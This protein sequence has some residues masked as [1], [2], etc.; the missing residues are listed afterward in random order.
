[1]AHDIDMSNGQANMAYVGQTPWH[2]LGQQLTP[3]APLEV[4]AVEAGLDWEPLRSPV[5]RSSPNGSLVMVPGR[6]VLYRSDNGGN[7]GIVSDGY[8]EMTPKQMLEFNRSLIEDMG[9]KMETAGSLMGGGKIWALAKTG[10]N[11]VLPGDD[12]VDGY[13]LAATSYYG[14][15]G[16]HSMSNL[17]HHTSVRVVCRNTLEWAVGANGK[18]ARV[19]VPHSTVV[20]P[21]WV[22]A[23]LGLASGESWAALAERAQAMAKTKI[24]L[25]DAAEY[26]LK[27]L[28]PPDEEGDMTVDTTHH[29]VEKRLGQLEGIRVSAPGQQTK[30][31][32]NT[33]WGLLNAV[34]YWTDHAIDTQSV[35]NRLNR[36]WFGDLADIKQRAYAEAQKM[37]A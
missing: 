10:E 4:W 22:K 16:E 29:L 36:A 23:Q 14:L 32:N 28:Y 24:T 18:K 31:A 11:F 35:D 9:F 6:Q 30:A 19:R 17:F 1:M 20:D 37:A 2:G 15:G 5:F 21:A 27:V 25:K 34:T 13:I 7:L 33:A 12:V 3:D 8:K 26:F